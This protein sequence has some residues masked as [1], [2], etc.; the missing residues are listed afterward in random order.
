MPEATTNLRHSWV[1]KLSAVSMGPNFE[2]GPFYANYGTIPFDAAEVY[3]IQSLDLSAGITLFHMLMF[4]LPAKSLMSLE[5]LGKKALVFP[6][7]FIRRANTN[8]QPPNI[9]PFP[10]DGLGVL[11]EETPRRR[12]MTPIWLGGVDHPN[13]TRRLNVR[14][15]LLPRFRGPAPIQHILDGSSETGVLVV[16]KTPET[17]GSVKMTIAPNEMYFNLPDSSAL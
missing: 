14:P 11:I 9:K 2:Y 1:R 10:N 8:N 13:E 5:T 7:K 3:M 4:C 12:L 16:R 6:T 17:W 15:S